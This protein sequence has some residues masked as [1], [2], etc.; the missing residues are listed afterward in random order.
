MREETKIKIMQ[1]FAVVN[2]IMQSVYYLGLILLPLKTIAMKIAVSELGFLLSLSMVIKT[3][4]SYILGI[5]MS[6]KRVNSY[7]LFLV[8]LLMSAFYSFLLGLL[9]FIETRDSFVNLV[10]FIMII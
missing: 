8:G 10:T 9:D 5:L 2:L 1:Q 7:Q 6:R 4:V 3:I